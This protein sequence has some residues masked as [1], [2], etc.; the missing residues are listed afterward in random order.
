MRLARRKLAGCKKKRSGSNFSKMKG[1]GKSMKQNGLR[2]L[3]IKS[4][5]REID[6]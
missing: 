1:R 4:R 3:N 6:G 2:Y 5:P